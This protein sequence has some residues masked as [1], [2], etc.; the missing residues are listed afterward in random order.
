MHPLP[1]SMSS[2]DAPNVFASAPQFITFCDSSKR[3]TLYASIFSP[4]LK[5]YISTQVHDSY[6][7]RNENTWWIEL[8]NNAL[9]YPDF[10]NIEKG[11][12]FSDGEQ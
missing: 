10:T 7:Q 2:G 9:K 12:A 4:T 8:L 3:R 5:Q 6:M 11:Q 1:P